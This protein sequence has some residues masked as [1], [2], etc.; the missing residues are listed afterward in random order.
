MKNLPGW[1]KLGD[2]EEKNGVLEISVGW[3]AIYDKYYMA[4]LGRYNGLEIQN[5]GE[6]FNPLTKKLE[7]FPI[8]TIKKW[9]GPN[10]HLRL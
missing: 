8:F 10:L 7:E 4:F 5:M 2:W 3:M 9:V 6:S 1:K